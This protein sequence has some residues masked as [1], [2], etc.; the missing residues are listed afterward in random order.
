MAAVLT[1]PPHPVAG[2]QHFLLTTMHS[3][4][5]FFHIAAA[6]LWLGGV[7]FMLFALRPAAMAQLQPP[8]R[9]PLMAAVLRRFFVLVWVAIGVLAVT[10]GYLMAISAAPRPLGWHVMA[11]LGLLM[12]LAF[13]HVYFRPFQELKT[14][15]AAGDWPAGGRAMERIVRFARVILGLGVVAIGSVVLL[16]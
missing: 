7:G 14:A 10:G 1:G 3:T 15:A 8:V 6:I 16:R 5:Q 13:G 11:G 4:A 9:I 2:K 12:F